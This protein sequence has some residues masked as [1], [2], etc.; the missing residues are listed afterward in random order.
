MNS[1]HSWLPISA[2]PPSAGRDNAAFCLNASDTP[3]A[4]FEPR[5]NDSP[6]TW[7][8]RAS[9]EV[10]IVKTLVTA[11]PFTRCERLALTEGT[12]P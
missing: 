1:G 11:G 6:F 3:T 7:I 10:S 2:A 4:G 5:W 12:L 8:K 9:A